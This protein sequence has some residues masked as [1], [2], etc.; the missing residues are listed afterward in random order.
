MQSQVPASLPIVS[1]VMTSYGDPLP[2]LKRA[3][4]SI[5]AQSFSRLELLVAFEPDDTNADALERDY[6]DPR[7]IVLKNP[8]RKGMAGSFNHCLEKARG[9]FIARMDSDDYSTPERIQIE[10]D[11]LARRP[12]V[13]IVGGGT[14]IINDNGRRIAERILPTEHKEIV[15][16]FAFFCPISHPTV[17]WDSRKTGQ[18]RYNTD[19]SVEDVELWFRLLNQGRRFANIPEYLI[20]YK[21]TNEWRRPQRN[22]RGNARIRWVYWRL[23]IRHPILLLG[24]GIFSVLA[25]MPKSVVDAITRRSRFSDFVRSIRP[26]E[27][28]KVR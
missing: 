20:E 13:D 21:Q 23:A 1:V 11:F 5:L 28:T 25:F 15:R 22:W 6:G 17:M 16:A 8:S 18:I 7:L 4:D 3:V 9:R 12:D 10:L 24:I 2:R 26:I 19:F 14:V 27:G